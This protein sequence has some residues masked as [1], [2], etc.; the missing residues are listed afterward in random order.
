MNKTYIS[1]LFALFVSG[2]I[3][4]GTDVP[5]LTG[6]INDNAQILLK[7]QANH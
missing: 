5:Y 1:L 6:R 4:R 3:A 7:L 2:W